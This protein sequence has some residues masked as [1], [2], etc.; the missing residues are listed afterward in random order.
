MRSY[1][2]SNFCYINNDWPK[3]GLVWDH[4]CMW[5]L[6]KSSHHS[7]VNVFTEWRS[8]A[9]QETQCNLN[10]YLGLSHSKISYL[11]LENQYYIPLSHKIFQKVE[12]LNLQEKFSM[13][14]KIWMFW[15]FGL[16]YLPT[17]KFYWISFRFE[18][19]IV[20]EISKWKRNMHSLC[21]KLDFI[22]T[23]WHRLTSPEMRLQV[24][25]FCW[26]WANRF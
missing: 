24:R 21:K 22:V 5:S 11:E 18:L 15:T 17:V 19:K 7:S 14:L 9:V 4:F 20:E 12:Q 26:F 3:Q 13:I 8:L 1:A 6:F 16:R 23:W 2:F 25:H 10:N